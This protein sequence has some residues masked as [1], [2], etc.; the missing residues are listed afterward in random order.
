[1]SSITAANFPREFD[2]I[3]ALPGVGRYTAGAVAS[4]AFGQR[5][6]IVDANV[7]RVLSR[8]LLLEGDLKTAANQSQLWEAATRIVEVADVSPREVNPAMMELG[9]LV[10]LAQKS[11][12]RAVSGQRILRGF[13]RESV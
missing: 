3:L 2:E 1:M 12:L 5:A 6:P 7:A 8:V 11:S 10:L 4:I 9:A 13:E